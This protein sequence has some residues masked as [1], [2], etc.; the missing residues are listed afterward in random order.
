MYGKPGAGGREIRTDL[1]NTGL[2]LEQR[3]FY[4]GFIREVK[5]RLVDE[6]RTYFRDNPRTITYR[7]VGSQTH[8]G[9]AETDLSRSKVLISSTRPDKP[10]KMV[11]ILVANASGRPR[12]LW[13]N[14]PTLRFWID[15]PE[16]STV[17]KAAVE[18]TGAEYLI[19]QRLMVGERLTGRTDWTVQ[20]EVRAIQEPEV[21][22]VGDLLHHGLVGQIRIALERLGLNWMPDAAS[23]SGLSE[24]KLSERQVMLTRTYSIGLRT[25]WYDDFFYQAVNISDVVIEEIV[26]QGPPTI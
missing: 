20:I 5:E 10:Q 4:F 21:D 3:E 16:Y 6:I 22:M 11:S 13:F 12:D 25:D 17:D 9:G 7:W 26:R 1:E 15:N 2:V 14:V 23:I 19:P 8:S 24:E 18:A